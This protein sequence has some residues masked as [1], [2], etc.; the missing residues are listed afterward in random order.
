MKQ[1][2]MLM[3]FTLL[4]SQLSFANDKHSF[5]DVEE[6]HWAKESIEYLV[7]SNVISGYSDGSFKPNK[8]I[9]IDEFM[10]LLVKSMG[11]QVERLEG[12]DWE[13]P[14]IRKAKQIGLFNM[15]QFLYNNLKL[16]S[17]ITREE[18]IR[19]TM[20][21][22]SITEGLPYPS[23]INQYIKYDITD[24]DKIYYEITRNVIDAYKLGIVSGLPDGSFKPQK[25]VTRAEAASVLVKFLDPSTRTP[26]AGNPYINKNS[27]SLIVP[28][29]VY[30]NESGKHVG[31]NHI[32]NFEMDNLYTLE[33]SY[34]DYGNEISILGNGFRRYPTRYLYVKML[35]PL[36][37]DKPINEVIDLAQY[38]FN[39]RNT[40]KGY[41][42][43]SANID[44]NSVGAIGFKSK[45]YLES[46]YETFN[47]AMR[48]IYYA[49]AI[50]FQLGF[51][52]NNSYD[53]R[54]LNDGILPFE[55]IVWKKPNHIENHKTYGEY[56][57]STYDEHIK[58]FLKILFEKESDKVWKEFVKGLYYEG[59]A[60]II[61]STLNNRDYRLLASSNTL[62]LRVSLKK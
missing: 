45:A 12:D 49:N 59:D 61:N 13:S 10:V 22:L 28:V 57:T 15:D 55:I 32:N 47:P 20:S 54:Y 19:I 53:N 7:E 51:S 46:V 4:F 52:P 6:N 60:Y 62:S 11:H 39:N 21:A 8:N 34:D 36:Y 30:E 44:R 27:D 18:M 16:T 29:R 43:V 50:D 33:N 41:L 38:L 9:K 17:D 1:I 3:L 14:Y 23:E 31:Y 2:L 48:S 58:A 35:A 24:S 56:F 26:Y 5:S 42:S 37:K 40:G 25:T